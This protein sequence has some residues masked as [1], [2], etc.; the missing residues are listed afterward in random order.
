MRKKEGMTISSR[1]TSSFESSLNKI[2]KIYKTTS[3]QKRNNDFTKTVVINPKLAKL[4]FVVLMSL[5]FASLS[6]TNN[7]YNAI[8]SFSI[9]NTINHGTNFVIFFSLLALVFF[10]TYE[11]RKLK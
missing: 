11:K 10:L 2:A 1:I 4:S 5:I 6:F 9:L 7:S 3:S 8:T